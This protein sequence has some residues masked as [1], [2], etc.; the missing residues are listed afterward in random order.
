MADTM[1]PMRPMRF[2]GAFAVVLLG[3]AGA[4]CGGGSTAQQFCAGTGI[5]DTGAAAN[6]DLG[7]LVGSPATISVSLNVGQLLFVGAND[8]AHYQLTP[9]AQLAPVLQ[10]E[11]GLPTPSGAHSLAVVYEAES[12]GTAVIHIECSPSDFCDRATMAIDV[13]VG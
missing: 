2:I 3:I 1:A 11:L 7:D 12:P 10:Q 5:A 4:G 9:A 8:C 6:V 13:S